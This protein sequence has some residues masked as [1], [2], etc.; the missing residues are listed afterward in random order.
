MS[1]PEWQVEGMYKDQFVLERPPPG[2]VAIGACE[3]PLTRTRDSR[4]KKGRKLTEIG[5]K[6]VGLLCSTSPKLI[7]TNSACVFGGASPFISVF[8]LFGMSDLRGGRKF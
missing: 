1:T 7:F 5:F 3:P 8:V 4:G 2:S 6:L